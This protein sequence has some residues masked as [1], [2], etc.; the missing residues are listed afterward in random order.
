MKILGIIV[1][2]VSLATHAHDFHAGDVR[3][4]HPFAVPTV[5]GATT[6]AAYLALENAGKSAD[7]LVAATSPRAKRIELHTMQSVGGVMRMREVDAITI[8]PGAPLKMRP[9]GGFHLM[10]VELDRPLKEGETFPLTL[11]F[12]KS[13]TVE[14]KAYVQT[15]KRVPPEHRH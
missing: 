14:V 1:M 5:A 7:R 8:A 2:F 12:E 9:G 10:M 13:G 6:G 4:I 3:I 15:P 11:R